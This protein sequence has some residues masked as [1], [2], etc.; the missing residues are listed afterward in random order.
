MVSLRYRFY[1]YYQKHKQPI[2]SI[3]GMLLII[4]NALIITRRAWMSDDAYITFRVVENWHNGFGLVWNVGERVQVYTH[5]LWLFLNSLFYL[6]TKEIYLTNLFLSLSISIIV[7]ILF[8]FQFRKKNLA[9]LVGLIIL[10]FSSAYVD[11]ST[12]GLENPLSHFIMALFLTIFFREKPARYQFLWLSLLAALAGLN[13]LNQLLIYLPMLLYV[14][15]QLPDRKRSFWQAAAGFLPLLGWEI[16]SII[17]YG[18]PFPNTYYAKLHHYLTMCEVIHQGWLYIRHTLLNDPVTGLVLI[19]GIGTSLWHRN[20]KRCM[21]V[22]GCVFYLLYVVSI[23][24]DFMEGRFFTTIFLCLVWVITAFELPSIK[25]LHWLWI[26]PAL[27]FLNLSASI[28]T[29]MIDAWNYLE[30]WRDGIVNERYVYFPDTGLFRDHEFN[31]VPSHPWVTEGRRLRDEAGVDLL[32]VDQFSVG[33]S[34]YY[35]GPKVFIIDTLGLGDALMARIP[36]GYSLNWRVG[37]FERVIPSGYAHAIYDGNPYRI[38]DGE[39]AIFTEKLWLITRGK[40]FTPERWQAIW[41]LNTRQYRRLLDKEKY[42]YP[43]LVKVTA[44]DVSIPLV[45]AAWN[46]PGVVQ[47]FSSGIEIQFDSEQ[48]ASKI[49]L[50]LAQLENFRILYYDTHH[51][52]VGSENYRIASTSQLREIIIDVPE[53][54]QEQ[55]Y[56]F[57]HILPIKSDRFREARFSL[58]HLI[59][60]E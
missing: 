10:S 20:W 32:V 30:P 60:Y 42:H 39:T 8:F 3:L 6:F 23:G 37:H 54:V 35:A 43:I 50:S 45:D 41:M 57:V 25:A 21:V 40:L 28:P 56:Q 11:Y 46:T 59:I 16:F 9:C 29:I 2:I 49:H 52:L 55:G 12:S 24:G 44:E 22:C 18:F 48:F 47:G 31:A 15:F 58:G 36:P 34:G 27:F 13:R 14:F 53:D 5:P 38:N 19:S 7:T 17:Y 51:Q 1:R 26:V 4:F 33:F